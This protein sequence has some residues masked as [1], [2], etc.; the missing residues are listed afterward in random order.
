MQGVKKSLEGACLLMRKIIQRE[1]E[2]RKAISYTSLFND[3][4]KQ[5]ESLHLQIYV[6]VYKCYSISCVII[7]LYLKERTLIMLRLG[8]KQHVTV[9]EYVHWF[10]EEH[11]KVS[12]F[13]G[14][15]SL[16][17]EKFGVPNGWKKL[18]A[19]RETEV[20]KS[21]FPNFLLRILPRWHPNSYAGWFWQQPR[22]LL[23]C[24][25][26]HSF[27]TTERKARCC[28]CETSWV[29]S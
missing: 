26:F 18:R 14:W 19:I 15:R 1:L 29:F 27:C 10:K 17:T 7:Q 24:C 21:R 25:Y 20:R 11:Q 5:R 2:K 13:Y 22:V 28:C 8:S 4:K 6:H 3:N 23:L 9:S 12:T 16:G